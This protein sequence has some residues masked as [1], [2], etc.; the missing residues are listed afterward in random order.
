MSD[1]YSVRGPPS[2]PKLYPAVRTDDLFQRD[3]TR[4][5][6]A[7]RVPCDFGRAREPFVLTA[8]GLT[9]QATCTLVASDVR[10]ILLTDEAKRPLFDPYC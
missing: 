9:Q 3:S 5:R 1:P 7:T 2:P 10:S 6:A 4:L 8:R